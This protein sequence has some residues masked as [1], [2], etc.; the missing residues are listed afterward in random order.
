MRKLLRKY[1]VSHIY[2]KILLI[3]TMLLHNNLLVP[4]QTWLGEQTFKWCTKM[5]SLVILKVLLLCWILASLCGFQRI[6]QTSLFLQ[7]H[8]TRQQIFTTLTCW[9]IQ[10][11]QVKVIFI[12]TRS[13]QLLFQ[14]MTSHQYPSPMDVSF[15]ATVT[16]RKSNM[17][18]SV[19]ILNHTKLIKMVTRLAKSVL[20]SLV[21]QSTNKNLVLHAT[22]LL[23]EIIITR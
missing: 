10:T 4:A 23:M 3:H 8:P 12:C 11:C 2:R 21:P 18:K 19:Q 17:K 13:M 16:P 5:K 9:S 14:R 7:S 22:R 15:G 20:I 1:K 6:P